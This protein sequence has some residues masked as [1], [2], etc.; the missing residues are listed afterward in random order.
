MAFPRD[1]RDVYVV[2]ECNVVIMS[3]SHCIVVSAGK[4]ELHFEHLFNSVTMLAFQIVLCSMVAQQCVTVLQ[5][6]GSQSMGDVI[7]ECA[8]CDRIDFNYFEDKQVQTAR[9]KNTL[10][11]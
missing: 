3:D 9:R 5:L 7:Q 10:P 6:D 2:H 4:R 1:A 11:C 8:V